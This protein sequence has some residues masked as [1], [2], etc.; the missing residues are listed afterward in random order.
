MIRYVASLVVLVGCTPGRL[1]L[2]GGDGTTS[3]GDGTTTF[4]DGDASTTF[5]DGDDGDDHGV[6]PDV[7]DAPVACDVWLQD[8]PLN[9][10]CVPYVGSTGTW[11]AF[12]CVPILGDG[13]AGDACVLDGKWAATDDCGAGLVCWNAI[14]S[15]GQLVGRC[16]D[17]CKGSIDNPQCAPGTTCVFDGSGA[18]SVCALSCHWLLQDCDEGLVCTWSGRSFTCLIS[19]GVPLGHP[20]DGFYACEAGTSCLPSEA[21]PSCASTSCCV[22]FCD[23][24]APSCSLPGTGCIDL[25]KPGQWPPI[26]LPL[27]CAVPDWPGL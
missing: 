21:L 25:F 3:S 5:G 17:L 15:E 4:G 9:Q 23:P 6:K 27:I 24:D 10:K 13:K 12:R 2:T 18:P 1:P 22:E 19:E 26:E 16:T 14:E 7:F 8:C 20:C 11:D